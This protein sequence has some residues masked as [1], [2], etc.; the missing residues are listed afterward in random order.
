[1]ER[2]ELLITKIRANTNLTDRNGVTDATIL[3][4]LNDAQKTIQS[5]I[6]QAELEPDLF[7]GTEI[8]TPEEVTADLPIDTFAANFILQV[9]PEGRVQKL[10]KI[11]S[12]ERGNKRGYFVENNTIGFSSGLIDSYDSFTLKYFRRLP[13]ID[14]RRGLITAKGA[15]SITVSGHSTTVGTR[16]GDLSDWITVV[17]KDGEIIQRA[18]RVLSF[19]SGTGVITTETDIDADVDVDQY[20]VMGKIASSHSE[21]PDECEPFLLDFVQKKVRS[22]NVSKETNNQSIFSEEQKEILI[23]LFQ[24]NSADPVYPPTT[25][26]DWP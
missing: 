13:E 10:D 11:Q 25:D 5:L 19:N 2:A 4:H 7:I 16:I 1:M 21:L 23:G 6:K 3:H 17:N 12:Y 14:I 15:N 24:G 8:V 18:I 22:K 26:T 20:V 9:A